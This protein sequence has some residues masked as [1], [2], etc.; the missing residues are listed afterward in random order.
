MMLTSRPEGHFR[1]SLPTREIK[2][3]GGTIPRGQSQ[4]QPVVERGWVEEAP[5]PGA[6][7]EIEVRAHGYKHTVTL[8]Q[9]QRWA[10]GTTRSPAEKVRRQRMRLIAKRLARSGRFTTINGALSRAR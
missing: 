1:C 5:G 3:E 7:L 9:I 6:R 2:F 4:A 10:N 8:V